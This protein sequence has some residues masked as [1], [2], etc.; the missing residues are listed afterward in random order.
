MAN[1]SRK[2]DGGRGNHIHYSFFFL[3]LSS[4]YTS[5]ECI[6]RD[7]E[8]LVS[9]FEIESYASSFFNLSQKPY[10]S[11]N[12]ERRE[13]TTNTRLRDA[14]ITRKR[15]FETLQKLFRDLKIELK[16]SETHVFWGPI[17][18]PFFKLWLRCV[19]IENIYLACYS[20]K[21]QELC[22]LKAR[23]LHIKLE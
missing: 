9:K 15:D 11:K 23:S 20:V 5:R 8:T 14:K 13:K 21:R 6:R 4:S 12:S 19:N 16:F 7:F 18:Y 10:T 2:G 17:L 22:L 1:T 3:Q